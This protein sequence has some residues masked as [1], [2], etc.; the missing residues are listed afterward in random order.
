MP[1][2]FSKAIG[3]NSTPDKLKHKN[4]TQEEALILPAERMGDDKAKKYHS[5][6]Y[7]TLDFYSCDNVA[8][9][10]RRRVFPIISI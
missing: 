4:K 10:C 6:S 3:K 2:H 5:S 8:R 9:N 1:Q 7:A